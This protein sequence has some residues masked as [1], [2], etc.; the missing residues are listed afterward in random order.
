M[1]LVSNNKQSAECVR[2]NKRVMMTG[3]RMNEWQEFPHERWSKSVSK[4][5]HKNRNTTKTSK[6]DCT[7]GW[8]PLERWYQTVFA[9]TWRK[10][11]NLLNV[12]KHELVVD[13]YLFITVFVGTL[14]LVLS[15]GNNRHQLR[16]PSHP[17][18]HPTSF[19]NIVF[20][21]KKNNC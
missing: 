3:V 8:V 9:S 7:E 21:E 1:P 18:S 5:S 12:L 6:T 2:G 20:P 4:K 11:V 10:L 17:T 15:C 16:V 13:P 14:L 19:S